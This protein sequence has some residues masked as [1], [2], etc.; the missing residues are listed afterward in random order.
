M[1]NFHDD[2]KI[3]SRRVHFLLYNFKSLD[4]MLSKCEFGTE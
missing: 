4:I 2:L 3:N 1:T